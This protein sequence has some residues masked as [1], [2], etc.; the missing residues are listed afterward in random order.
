V[1]GPLALV[2]RWWEIWR[3]GDVDLLDEVVTDPF[4]RHGA[5]GT[6]TWAREDLKQRIAEYRLSMRLATVRI[7]GYA[8]SDGHVW[9]RATMRGVNLRSQEPFTMSMLQECRVEGDQLAETW[10]LNAGVDW[11]VG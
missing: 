4:T 10:L 1:L 5:Q 7:D 8:V 9:S 6:V 11:A 3:D 2:E